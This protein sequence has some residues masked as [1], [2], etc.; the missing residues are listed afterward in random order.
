[1]LLKSRGRFL[2][3]KNT[4]AR[5][6]SGYLRI[7]S[8]KLR[9]HQRDFAEMITREM[10]KPIG[11]SLSSSSKMRIHALEVDLNRPLLAFSCY[12]VKPTD[13]TEEELS[14]IKELERQLGLSLLAVRK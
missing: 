11:Q 3:W 4:S 6:R 9:E 8:K 1:M 2:S 14:R 12:D 10:G 5:E 13:V 7:L